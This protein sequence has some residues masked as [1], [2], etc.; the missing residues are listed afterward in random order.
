MRVDV[1]R[2]YMTCREV[3]GMDGCGNT[4]C[5]NNRR[6]IPPKDRDNG[7]LISAQRKAAEKVAA[8]YYREHGA[9]DEQLK[10]KRHPK[11]R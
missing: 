11:R 9:Q 3:C 7:A 1:R 6:Y 2:S 5:S 4:Y 10:K 8:R